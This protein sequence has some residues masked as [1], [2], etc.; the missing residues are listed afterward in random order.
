MLLAILHQVG[1]WVY[2]NAQTIQAVAA[3]LAFVGLLVYAWDTRLIRKATLTT[4]RATLAQGDAS[5]RPYFQPED[6]ENTKGEKAFEG[7]DYYQFRNCGAGIA[8]NVRWRFL[9]QL[10]SPMKRIGSCAVG[11][12]K[13]V[14]VAGERWIEFP[15]IVEHGGLY[16]QY[17]DTSGLTYW[18][19]IT[20]VWMLDKT[21]HPLV[22]TG[23]VLN[24]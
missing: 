22:D 15:E 10:G 24:H 19:T 4:T 23:L 16:L 17:E 8:L 7:K 1:L 5:R 21:I 14:F 20:I 11:Q 13:Y 9:N 6:W 12:V 3:I 2:Y 18:T